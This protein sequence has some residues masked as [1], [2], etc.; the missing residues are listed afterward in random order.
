MI[1]LD[2]TKQV[3]KLEGELTIFHAAEARDWLAAELARDPALELDLSAVT[4][5]DSAGIQVLFWLKREG[6]A[7]GRSIPFAHHSPA[8]L[9]V[10]DQL[11]LVGLFGDTILITPSA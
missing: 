11:N 3:A 1:Q 10:F 6:Q 2:R 4:E 9:E 5:L 7:L 8:V